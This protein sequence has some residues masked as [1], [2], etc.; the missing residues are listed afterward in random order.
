MYILRL[1][2]YSTATRLGFI[3]SSSGLK[4]EATVDLDLLLMHK[5]YARFICF[6]YL[7]PQSPSPLIRLLPCSG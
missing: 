7:D 6:I 4:P 5:L 3:I 1:L 2:L